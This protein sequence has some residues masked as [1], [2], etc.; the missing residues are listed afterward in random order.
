L[1]ITTASTIIMIIIHLL[2][3]WCV[4]ILSHIHLEQWLLHMKFHQLT[5]TKLGLSAAD[6]MASYIEVHF[7]YL[8]IKG[9]E[10]YRLYW[11][12]NN[13]DLRIPQVQQN[14]C[15]GTLVV[16]HFLGWHNVSMICVFAPI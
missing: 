3:T 4:P 2:H 8:K 6:I 10:A 7:S 11:H 9:W 13:L 14:T 5:K 12:N 1:I 15:V 16:G